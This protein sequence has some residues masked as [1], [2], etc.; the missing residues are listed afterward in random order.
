MAHILNITAPSSDIPASNKQ[1]GTDRHS[2]GQISA[3]RRSALQCRSFDFIEDGRLSSHP[4]CLKLPYAVGL[5]M[6]LFAIPIHSTQIIKLLGITSVCL[7]L[8]NC[9]SSKSNETASNTESGSSSSSSTSGSIGK[10]LKT[11]DT[12]AV[13]FPATY[14]VTES[15][16]VL[17]RGIAA[18]GTAIDSISVN[19]AAPS[20]LASTLY[21]GLWQAEVPLVSGE[22]AISVTQMSSGQ[23]NNI[24]N[25][26]VNKRIPMTLP[27]LYA[28]VDN[29]TAIVFDRPSATYLKVNLETGTR[30]IFLDAKSDEDNI[31]AGPRDML[32]VENTL[33]VLDGILNAVV[34]INLTD[35]SRDL[36][37]QNTVE[38]TSTTP[39]AL[40]L[41]TQ[42]AYDDSGASP[43]LIIV[44]CI[45]YYIDNPETETIEPEPVFCSST[46]NDSRLAF[47]SLDLNTG[48]RTALFQDLY[49]EFS[50]P[51]MLT[52]NSLVLNADGTKAYILGRELF[53]FATGEL[54]LATSIVEVDLASGERSVLTSDTLV[55]E[56]QYVFASAVD[57]TL[58][59]DG[60]AL[61][62]LDGV[63]QA[64]FSVD[65]ADGSRSLLSN[66]DEPSSD[67]PLLR[68]FEIKRYNDNY[69][70]L[71]SGQQA[72][73]QI[74]AESGARS[75][76]ASHDQVT[77]SQFNSLLSPASIVL[78]SDSTKLFVSDITLDSIF[79]IDLAS[80]ALTPITGGANN[81]VNPILSAP[82]KLEINADNNTLFVTGQI[83]RIYD[84][85]Q[86]ILFSSSTVVPM[87]YSVDIATGERTAMLDSLEALRFLFAN[88]ISIAL[89]PADERI[90]FASH[91]DNGQPGSS[92]LTDFPIQ[93][94]GFISAFNTVDEQLSL[95]PNNQQRTWVETNL[96]RPTGF[97]IDS[98][99]DS[100]RA[101]IL[102]GSQKAILAMDLA[103]GE[104]SLLS[105]N[106]MP[107][108][109]TPFMQPHDL[110]LDSSQ[111]VAYV[112]DSV[113][114][115]LIKVD[116]ESGG[117]TAV[118]EA[119]E[120]NSENPLQQS[121]GLTIDT[122]K[123][124]AY[125]VDDLLQTIVVVDLITEKRVYMEPRFAE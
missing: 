17:V 81:L 49:E 12:T 36:I 27:E 121:R 22:N 40:R 110:I 108:D 2:R 97:K 7:L 85:E 28:L 25:L 73:I 109:T 18:Q 42:F 72:L 35:G 107:N 50:T 76:I 89:N 67:Y 61:I 91:A 70:V 124:I 30:E 31:P 119:T 37:G 65:L 114:D 92:R 87:L 26:T 52:A 123:Q 53:A 54:A 47:F 44:D 63:G 69:L 118:S 122:E 78:N 23:S 82:N 4:F 58:N 15:D 94:I 102:D 80:N 75:V 59:A 21:E 10:A 115:A 125:V 51:Y 57:A 24:A 14:S 93:E 101:L 96:Q 3:C 116:L 103:S 5:L 79:D 117:R 48:E 38:D 86:E 6:K 71:D 68:P 8:I 55:E 90:L 100:P 45:G 19:G 88:P 74:N 64:V 60:T 41:P 112:T 77:K 29:T 106:V 34:R 84:E 9:G 113:A 66:F 83:D 104:F 1:A 62:V 105:N 56:D 20:A 13:H 39:F 11:S 95:W 99:A 120:E 33:Y 43:R 98:Q 32:I 111:G 46:V 16:S